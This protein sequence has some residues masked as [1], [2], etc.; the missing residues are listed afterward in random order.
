[1][2]TRVQVKL[3][4]NYDT[5]TNAD[6]VAQGPPQY[7]DGHRWLNNLTGDS[8]ELT[9]ADGII[10]TQIET[11]LDAKID[12]A[13]APTFNRVFNECIPVL[14]RQRQVALDESPD[15]ITRNDLYYLVTYISLYA[16]WTIAGAAF[17]VDDV[18]DIVGDLE[19]F[20]YE[21]NVYIFGTRRNNGIKGI[22]S[23]DA[24]GLTFD[25]V[26]VGTGDRAVIALAD[27]PTDLELIVGRMIWYD[28]V[29]KLDG[30]GLSSEK[31]GTYGIV[32]Q[33]RLG[34]F[35]YPQDVVSGLDAYLSKSPI[36]DQEW[37]P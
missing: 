27:V 18:D 17:S 25:T 34:S 5:I 3:N 35:Q 12:A 6:P 19:D 28:I 13:L 11:A 4:G 37:I 1:M 31:T 36:A 20:E 30:L 24:A 26:G 15:T 7:L 21:D 8:F 33:F 2:T 32:T 29:L 22:E 14:L 9:D 23:V 16:D 10:W